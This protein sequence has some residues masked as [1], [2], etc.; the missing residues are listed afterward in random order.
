[1]SEYLMEY[2]LYGVPGCE[3]CI[4]IGQELRKPHIYVGEYNISGEFLRWAEYPIVESSHY[5][6]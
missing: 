5:E 6:H 2:C 1:M 4:G 3:I